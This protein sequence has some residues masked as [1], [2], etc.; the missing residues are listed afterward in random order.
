MTRIIGSLH[1][2][3]KKGE[4]SIITLSVQQS[5]APQTRSQLSCRKTRLIETQRERDGG[6]K[7][8]GFTYHTE[9]TGMRY[10]GSTYA[11]YEGKAPSRAH[12]HVS[13]ETEATE[14][15]VPE[16]MVVKI[17]PNMADAPATDWV[18]LRQMSMRG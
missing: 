16:I 12:A 7:K 5:C 6:H 1:V 17:P 15:M 11:K 4:E 8:K 10:L 14:P 18:A 13:L 3:T 9:R 2:K